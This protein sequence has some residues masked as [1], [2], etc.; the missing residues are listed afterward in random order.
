MN[1]KDFLRT[2]APDE[3]EAFA[4]AANTSVA[5]LYQLAG[6]HRDASAKMAVKIEK[7]SQGAV[8]RRELRP[9]YFF[10]DSAA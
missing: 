3:R 6:G 9:D 4:E 5:Y 1:L 8:T 7:A 2:L 10:E